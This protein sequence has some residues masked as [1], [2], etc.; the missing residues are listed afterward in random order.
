MKDYG[1]LE[2]AQI[3]LEEAVENVFGVGH[4]NRYNLTLGLIGFRLGPMEN[5]EVPR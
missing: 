1:F 2:P 4:N 5:W 3:E